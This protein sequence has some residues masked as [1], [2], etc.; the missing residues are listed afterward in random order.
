MCLYFDKENKTLGNDN[1]FTSL[2]ERLSIEYPRESLSTH[3]ITDYIVN[4]NHFD[5]AYASFSIGSTE[6][7]LIQYKN[8]FEEFR[9]QPS[10]KRSKF[11]FAVINNKTEEIVIKKSMKLLHS[12]LLADGILNKMISPQQYDY[13]KSENL[14]RKMN[15]CENYTLIKKIDLNNLK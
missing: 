15:A 6:E 5:F 11:A 13:T 12:M 9:S 4:M 8:E 10:N 2:L 3:V 1:L 7:L 14:Y